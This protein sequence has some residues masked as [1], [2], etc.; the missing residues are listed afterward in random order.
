MRVVPR[1]MFAI[2]CRRMICVVM[3]SRWPGIQVRVRST[4][5]LATSAWCTKVMIIVTRVVI[6]S[7]VPVVWM[8]WVHIPRA[9]MIRRW[10]PFTAIIRFLFGLGLG[11]TALGIIRLR[12]GVATLGILGPGTIPRGQ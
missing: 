8:W 9:M 7:M 4:T 11:V 2:G 5:L 3:A 1:R 6:I 10:S 12:L